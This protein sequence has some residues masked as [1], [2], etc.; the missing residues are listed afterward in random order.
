MEKPDTVAA[1]DPEK[2]GF[3]SPLSPV[4]PN[5]LEVAQ[6]ES[7]L[8]HIVQ[9]RI[10]DPNIDPQIIDKAE[11]ALEV[12]DKKAEVLLGDELEEDSPYIEVR[13]AVSN[14]DDPDMP[15]NTI[16]AWLLGLIAVIVPP[17]V[18]QLLSLRFPS[19]TITA[20]VIIIFVYPIGKFLEK[21]LPTWKLKTRFGDLTLNPGPFNI[22]EHSLISIMSLMSS[23]SAY[24][25]YIPA[26]QRFVYNQNPG[27]GYGILITLSTQLLGLS[28]ACFMRRFLVYPASMIYPV[29][30]P[31]ATLLN[32]LHGWDTSAGTHKGMSRYKFFW[33]FF[34]IVFCWQFFPG[35]IFTMLS[36]GNWFCL[37]APDNVPL[38]QVFGASSLGLLPLTLDWQTISYAQDPLASPWWAEANMLGGFALFFLVVVPA[39]YY[40]NTW[41]Q[42]FLPMFSSA[43]FDRFG[44]KYDVTKVTQ[45]IAN[46]GFVF[47]PEGY[48]SYSQQYIP[49]ALAVSYW[50]SFAA[51]TGVVTH[52][53]LFHGKSIWR[54]FRTPIHAEMDVH[55][56]LMLRYKE[57]PYWC[58]FAL[59]AAAFGMGIAAIYNW[60]TDMPWWA[61]VIA[62]LFGAFFILPIGVVLALSNQEVGLNMIS[63][64]VI[65]YMLPGR[66]IAMMIF[67]T[68]MYM[69][70]YQGLQFVSDQKLAH[71][72]KV[73][74]RSVF[75]AQVFAT[76]VGAIVQILVQEWAFN[77][78][79]DVCTDAAQHSNKFTCASMYVFGTASKVWGL[80][81]PRAM[82]DAGKQYNHL[83]YG[84]LI[85]ALAPIPVW[86][87]SKRF[88]KSIWRLINMPVIFTATGNIPPA[89]GMM[90]TAVGV[91]G[92][93]FQFLIKRY[94]S[95]WWTKY[96]YILSAALNGGS[97]IATVVIFF[98]LQFPKGPNREF[99][100][101]GWWGNTAWQ[102]TAD[103]NNTPYWQVPEGGF[104]G[105]P[106]ELGRTI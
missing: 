20:Y 85:G 56:R 49:T 54:Q 65:G 104:E 17:G 29:N 64:L 22:K 92:F 47:S 33:I 57:T 42:K 81:G 32:S 55:T 48:N 100:N 75:A 31:K 21:V 45:T 94:R 80:I 8:H 101:S 71:Y 15:V 10:D 89:T 18:N 63:E 13:A 106:A 74:P 40:T 76:S 39:M 11:E 9:D 62:I 1:G 52:V 99:Y 69:V 27:V 50:L 77:N 103:A 87:L 41:N 14:V 66:P 38:N 68:T 59:F 28:F 19:T 4:Y 25:T 86:F 53:A 5:D 51:T 24:A 79:Q 93:V 3:S 82:F 30:L 102:N 34:A 7:H 95:V 61:F 43:T 67:K 58:Y 78:I 98:A 105:T 73:P 70:C 37:I 96:N 90:Y 12:G 26:V 91:W 6:A 88:P 72:M 16:R 97:T 2:S 84:F 23:Q 35:Y 46:G 60:F 44:N 83:L 36:Q